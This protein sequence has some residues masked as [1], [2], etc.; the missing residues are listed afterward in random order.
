MASSAQ[1]EVLKPSKAKAPARPFAAS[2]KSSPV[3]GKD[4]QGKVPA[5]WVFTRASSTF[6]DKAR[7]LSTLLTKRYGEGV[8]IA[9]F[10]R[11]LTEL[12]SLTPEQ[13]KLLTIDEELLGMYEEY[14]VS[15]KARDAERE[16]FRTSRS[17]VSVEAS[18][19]SAKEILAES[20]DSE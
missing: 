19:A 20:K 3:I 18:L 17:V 2:T 16:S 14:L 15:R 11:A 9:H 8:S 12:P 6:V 5:W 1:K 4:T 13:R 10:E 7:M